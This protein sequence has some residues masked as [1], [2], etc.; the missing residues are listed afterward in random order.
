MF[1]GARLEDEDSVVGILGESCGDDSS[2]G[3]A[4]DDHEVVVLRIGGHG[5]YL[6]PSAVVLNS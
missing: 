2:R 4:A 5:G 3:A 6:H 1:S